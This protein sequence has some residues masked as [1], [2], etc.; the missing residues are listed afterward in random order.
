MALF[1]RLL[2]KMMP[3]VS[4]MVTYADK[5]LM[6][7]NVDTPLSETYTDDIKAFLKH[8]PVKINFT[9]V[10]FC[11]RGHIQIQ[12]NLKDFSLSTNGL[13]IIPSG[14]KAEKLV[15]GDDSKLI[16]LIMPDI[17]YA[18][19]ASFHNSLYAMS[20]FTSPVSINLNDTEA[21]QCINIYKMMKEQ[22]MAEEQ[23]VKADLVKAYIQLLAGVAAVSFEK[24][25][26]E[27]KTKISTKEQIYRDFLTNLSEEYR[28][29]KDIAYYAAKAGLTPKYFASVIYEVSGTH[30]LDLV[31]EQVVLDAQHLLKEGK[32][33]K[34]VCSI[35]NFSSQSQFTSYFKTAVGI[36]PGEFIKSRDPL[37][38]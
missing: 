29:H 37:M 7:D 26:A 1:T 22:L 4:G 11:I 14:T 30:P 18:P 15:I 17:D 38:K 23:D 12:C 19:P 10:I 36:P 35:L 20:N 2:F 33:I 21:K 34:E 27:S 6:Y 16:A 9:A 28:E 8:L 32:S 24:W 3:K 31:K 13:C 5:L 25:K